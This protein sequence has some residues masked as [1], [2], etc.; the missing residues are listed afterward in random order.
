MTFPSRAG[1]SG[2][3]HLPWALPR[4][5]QALSKG[6]RRAGG[7]GPYAGHVPAGV[8]SRVASSVFIHGIHASDI[9]ANAAGNWHAGGQNGRPG[10]PTARRRRANGSGG[11]KAG[12]TGNASKT[13]KHHRKKLFRRPRGS[14]LESFFD[15]CC[16]DRPGCYEGFVRRR[17]SPRQRFCS[18][19]CR[20]AMERVWE[21]ERRWRRRSRGGVRYLRRRR[22]RA[23]QP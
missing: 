9:A 7:S 23:R 8:C 11:G 21:R 12:A 6:K 20:R 22:P 10:G 14:S 2:S 4:I 19:A 16:C 3:I 17:R 15:G 5:L 18:H 13:E 1:P